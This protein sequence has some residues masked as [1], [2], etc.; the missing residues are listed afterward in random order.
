MKI[1]AFEFSSPQRSVAVITGGPSSRPTVAEVIET[2]S[3]HVMKPLGMVDEALTQAGL[4]REQIES[5]AIGLGP[6]SYTGIRLAIALAQGWQLAMGI[7]LLGISSAD[8]I[9]AQAQAEGFTGRCCVIVDAQREEFYAASYELQA[10]AR[11]TITPLQLVTLA[12]VRQREHA[13]EL[14]IGPEVNRWFPAGCVVFPRAAMLGQLGL[15]QTDFVAGDK[16]E[17][18]YLREARFVKAP[19]A[20][21]ERNT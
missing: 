8:C 18:I 19:P 4:A 10:E 20:R 1:L 6:G 5:L 3:G 7:K 12:E 2:A 16:L 17:P 14:L 11:R 9:A 15:G 21:H 13:G